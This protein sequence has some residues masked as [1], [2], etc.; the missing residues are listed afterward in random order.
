MK[1]RPLLRRWRDD[2][3]GTTAI[4][5]ALVL[6]LFLT[7]LLGGIWTGLLMISMSS[8]DLAV[9]SAA[10]CYAVDATLCATPSAAQTYAQGRYAGLAS[11]AVFTAS[12]TGCGHTV[13]ATANFNL[14]F[15]PGVGPVP[16]SASACYPG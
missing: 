11:S 13:S 14:N 4:E 15:V 3:Q 16:L 8:L 12:N 7:V 5:Y 1:I 6:P 2:A 10:R 9:E